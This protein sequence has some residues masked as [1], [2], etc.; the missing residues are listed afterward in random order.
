MDDSILEPGLTESGHQEQ[1]NLEP[2][3]LGLELPADPEAAIQ[4]LLGELASAR[5]EAAAYLDDL[6]SVAANFDNFRKRTQ[7]EMADNVERASHRVLTRLLPVLDSL[8]LAAAHEPE[9]DSDAKLAGGIRSTQRLLLDELA[10][11]GLEPIASVGE[12][13][14]PH[15]HEAVDAFGDGRLVVVEEIRRGYLLAGRVLRPA[16][17]VVASES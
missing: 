16:L 14:N 11:E 8:D 5:A 12:E 6:R 1:A 15:L 9:S 2:A 17:V 4:V 3:P 13:F 7:R 10:K